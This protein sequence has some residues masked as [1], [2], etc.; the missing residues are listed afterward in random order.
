LKYIQKGGDI[1]ARYFVDLSSFSK[2]ERT[3]LL[4]LLKDCSFIANPLEENINIIDVVGNFATPIEQLLEISMSR[5][6]LMFI[7]I[8]IPRS[9]ASVKHLHDS[10]FCGIPP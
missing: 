1:L 5:F 2:D 7:I 4:L 3:R 9:V 10:L 8:F 6:T